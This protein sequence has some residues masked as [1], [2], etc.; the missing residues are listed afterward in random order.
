[1]TPDM[2]AD[3]NIEKQSNRR[4]KQRFP[5]P[6]LTVRLKQRSI[7]SLGND[8]RTVE[9]LDFNRYGIA[10]SSKEPFKKGNR[11]YLSFRGPYIGLENVAAQ[12]VSCARVEDGFRIGAVFLYWQSEEL[13]DVNIDNNLSR[14]ERIYHDQQAAVPSL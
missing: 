8:W 5:I 3:E 1:M 13:Y 4:I 12:V 9:G 14:I 2:G 10:Y 6:D 11:V 7:F